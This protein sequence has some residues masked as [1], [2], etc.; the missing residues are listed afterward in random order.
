MVV[1][2]WCGV[3]AAYH[4]LP[5][6]FTLDYEAIKVKVTRISVLPF[7]GYLRGSYLN[8][9]NNLL[10]KVALAVPLGFAASF[11]GGRSRVAFLST[12]LMWVIV[13]AGVFG[14]LEAGQFFLPSRVPDPT[15]VLVG[16]AG[17]YA[18]LVLGRWVA[19]ASIDPRESG[20]NRT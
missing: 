10:S 16:V 2:V 14:V 11:V 15:D 1:G 19:P 6:D 5:Y 18:G 9:F 4:W 12:T 3:L 17:T 20:R 7:A 8:A 13:A